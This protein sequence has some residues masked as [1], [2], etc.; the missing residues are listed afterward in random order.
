MIG[1]VDPVQQEEIID[2]ADREPINLDDLRIS[3]VEVQQFDAKSIYEE[4]LNEKYGRD[5]V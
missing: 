3:A 5:L 4:M 2:P 1:E